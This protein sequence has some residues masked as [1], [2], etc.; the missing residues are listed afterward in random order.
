MVNSSIVDDDFVLV[1]HTGPSDVAGTKLSAYQDEIN[2]FIESIAKD[3][4]LVNKY[5][6][7]NPE[8]G[9]QEHKAHAYLTDFMKSKDGWKV[10]T[11]AYGLATA[12]IAVFDTGKKGPVVSFNIEMGILPFRTI[13]SPLWV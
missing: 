4:W 13:S 6:H 3:L 2:E 8:L 5:I 9:Y 12:W 7:D 10:T 1:N 11:S